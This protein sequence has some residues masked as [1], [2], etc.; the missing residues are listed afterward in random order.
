MIESLT[1]VQAQLGDCLSETDDF[2]TLQTDGTTKFG[3]HY[4][5]YDVQTESDSYT[6][7]LRHV[8][9]G[10]SMDTLKTLKQI[11]DDNDSVQ[12]SLGHQAVSSK[13]IYKIKNTM[14]DRHAAEKLFNE[15]LH[16]FREGILPDVFENWTALTQVFFRGLH[17]VV[18]LAECADK[19][20]NM[21]EISILSDQ[22]A[23][24]GSS[25]TQRLVRTACKAF[26][27]RG[28]QQ[29]GTSTLFRS[30]LKEQGIFKIPLAQFVGNHF[31]I[32]FYDAAG[33]YYL[34]NHMIKFIESVHGR[35]ANQLL[36]SVLK[37]LKNPALIAGSRA[38]G[39]INKIITGP[40]W[41]KLEESSVSVL[42]MGS[43]Y[44][45]LK[46]KFDLWSSD[47]SAHFS[48]VQLCV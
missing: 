41:R 44:C 48:M 34:R 26:H 25:G 17:Y 35:S 10:S 40:L 47:S 22:I 28:S 46:E 36:A 3:H 6:L 5:A 45:K 4:A 38:L 7:G 39:L 21:W 16:D 24:Q 37:D 32:L 13:I 33:I 42:E 9:S 12:L 1:V 20:V 18:G 23:P 2:M 30:Y 19:A 15:V 14:S 27:H 11:L 43:I 8:F 31:N 29:C